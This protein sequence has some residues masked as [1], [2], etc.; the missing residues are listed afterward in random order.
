MPWISHK[1]IEKDLRE[2]LSNAGYY[3]DSAEFA[4]L[5]LKAIKRPGW[6]QVFVFDVRAKSHAG[7]WQELFGVCRDDERYRQFE[8]HLGV[9]PTPRDEQFRE[10]SAGTDHA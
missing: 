7:E 1:T 5:E 4:E 2:H 10:W 8:V 3:G 6:V 9:D